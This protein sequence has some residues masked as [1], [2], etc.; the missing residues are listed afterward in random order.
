M[1]RLSG[2]LKRTMTV[3][4]V[5]GGTAALPPADRAAALLPLTADDTLTLACTNGD[6]KAAYRVLRAVMDYGY[7]HERPSRVRLV[8]ADETAYKAYTFQWNM[9]FAE[10]KPAHED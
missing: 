5:C 9:W 2:P 7:E 10:R 8:C 3:E 4:I 6:P 1:P